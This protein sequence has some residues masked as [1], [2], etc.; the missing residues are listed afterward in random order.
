MKSGNLKFL[1][2]SGP[3]QGC[4]ETVA[5]SVKCGMD[6]DR[7]CTTNCNEMLVQ[8]RHIGQLYRIMHTYCALEKWAIYKNEV[9][10]NLF[11]I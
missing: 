7:K 1:E 11:L 9:K 3:L 6:T 10:T 8:V 5:R 4:N 2:P